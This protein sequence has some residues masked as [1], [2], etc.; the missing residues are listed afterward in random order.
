MSIKSVNRKENL[1]LVE[2]I[3]LLTREE[4]SFKTETVPGGWSQLK[5]LDIAMF[6]Y[7][8]KTFMVLCVLN[9]RT[10]TRDPFFTNA[11]TGNKLLSCFD[12]K[13]TSVDSLR[14]ILESLYNNDL[15]ILRKIGTYR[16][17]KNM[18]SILLGKRRYKTFYKTNISGLTRF[19]LGK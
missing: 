1:D 11:N 5:P 8:E 14:A 13:K 17:F 4:V 9:E 6:S 7:D 2:K 15:N 3:L 16:Y 19:R 10:G 12:L 18:F